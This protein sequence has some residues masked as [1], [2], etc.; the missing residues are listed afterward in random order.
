MI[1]RHHR[2]AK[3]LLGLS[4]AAGLLVITSSPAA[5]IGFGPR[6]GYSF[7]PDQLVLGLQAELFPVMVVFDFVPSIDIGFGDDLTVTTINGDL[8]YNFPSLPST[9]VSIFVLGGPTIAR[10]NPDNGQSNTEVGLSL[11]GG[12][13]VPL[14]GPASYYGEV[15]FGFGD[16]PDLKAMVGI[17]FGL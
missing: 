5:A 7:D 13:R 11:G 17:V 3:W 14:T 4:A 1:H 10:I 6:G 16:V 9:N 8:Q 12:L 15:R 2:I